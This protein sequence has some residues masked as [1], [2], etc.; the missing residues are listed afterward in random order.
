[1]KMINNIDSHTIP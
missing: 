1:M